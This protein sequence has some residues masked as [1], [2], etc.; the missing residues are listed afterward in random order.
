M[1]KIVTDSVSDL[2][3]EVVKD[4]DITVVPMNVHFGKEAYKDGVE[5]TAGEFY[6]KLENST[7]LPKTSAPGPG[8]FAD[9][10]DELAEKCS[11]IMGIFLSHKFSAVYDAA[12]QGKNLMKN[13]C[14]IELVDSRAAIMMEGM[15]VIEAAKKALE[16]VSLNELV[17]LVTN[18]I[19][20]IHMRSAMNDFKYLVM[21]GRIGKIQ[22]LLGTMLKVNA[23]NTIEDGVAAPV[24]R[25]N[26]RAKAIEWLYEY[27]TSFKKI[28]AIA[29][30]Y[31]TNVAEAKELAQRMAAVFPKVPIYLS[32][33]SPVIGTHAGPG[34]LSITVLE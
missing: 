3:P 10:F 4:L 24:T 34:V 18:T 17:N 21:G 9:V 30:E 33:V 32:Q 15:L 13:K 6:R 20:R 14:P 12:S 29:V 28:K 26:T 8:V 7:V 16:G 1:I 11:G 2:P 27:V 19:P 25:I 5:I 22:A 23:I 31:G